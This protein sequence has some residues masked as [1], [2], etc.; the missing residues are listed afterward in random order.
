M[1]VWECVT[2]HVGAT[3]PPGVLTY[4]WPRPS[5]P[6][7]PLLRR[8]LPSA[9]FRLP[10][11]TTSSIVGPNPAAGPSVPACAT[12]TSV[13]SPRHLGA[14]PLLS[15]T[16]A[17]SS[18]LFC[19]FVR[20]SSPPDLPFRRSGLRRTPAEFTTPTLDG[21]GLRDHLLAR[22]VGQASYP[23]L[24][25]RVA[26]LLHASFRPCLATSRLR[27]ANPVPFIKA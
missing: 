21:Y 4:D 6:G 1:N 20:M 23:V 27:F 22:P 13:P 2:L 3:A 10:G 7:A 26:A 17:S 9:F 8:T 19:R 16:K 12:Q 18:W 25:H 15:L 11:S 5:T 24:V 14:S